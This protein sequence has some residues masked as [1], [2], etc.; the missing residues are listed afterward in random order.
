M[1][2]VQFKDL[3]VNDVFTLD[4]VEYKRTTDQKISCCKVLNAVNTAN[5][6]QKIQVKP[7]TTVQIND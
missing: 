6:E 1:K 3:K 2:E 4:G 7:L 5:A